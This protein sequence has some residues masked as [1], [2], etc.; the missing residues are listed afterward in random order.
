MIETPVQEIAKPSG[1]THL[2]RTYMMVLLFIGLKAAGNLSLAWGMKHDTEAVSAN[3]LHYVR[4]MFDPFVAAGVI[5]LIVSLLTRMALLSRADLTF[6][7]PV[8]AIGYV[9]AT[10]LGKYFLHEVVTPERWAGTFLVFV[11]AVL[12][13]STNETTTGDQ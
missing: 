1:R 5:L 4:A 13:G 10:F 8:T 3:P 9:L 6:I 7:L 2:V 12:V 11:G